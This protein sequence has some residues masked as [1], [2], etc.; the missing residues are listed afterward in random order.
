MHWLKEM[1]Y[2]A[3]KGF[4][5]RLTLPGGWMLSIQASRNHYCHPR[6]TGLPASQY[7]EWELAVFRP[8]GEWAYV[9]RDLP[10]VAER[11]GFEDSSFG[12]AGHVSV[13][14]VD[15]LINRLST[16]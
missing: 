4:W 15:W 13:S 9:C 14:D 6:V 3:E 8:D 11:I 16:N 2:D 12:V 7:T 1:K 5:E 10:D